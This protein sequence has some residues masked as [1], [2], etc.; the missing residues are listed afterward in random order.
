MSR[1]HQEAGAPEADRRPGRVLVAMSGGVDSSVAA[2]LLQRSGHEV[3]GVYMSNGIEAAASALPH[4]T[5]VRIVAA[6]GDV[7]RPALAALLHT[8]RGGALPRVWQT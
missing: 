1:A 2:G 6:H 3:L 7:L 5:L 8:L 4:V